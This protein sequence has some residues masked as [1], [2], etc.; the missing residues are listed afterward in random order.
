MDRPRR[1]KLTTFIK[2]FSDR[3][4]QI[5]QSHVDKTDIVCNSLSFDIHRQIGDP[6]Q[7]QAYIIFAKKKLIAYRNQGSTFSPQLNI[8]GPK[9]IDN[10][11]ATAC[12]QC[13]AI[14]DLIRKSFLWL[15]ENSMTMRRNKVCL[16][17]IF[18]Y[19]VVARFT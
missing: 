18:F 19:K 5:I 13:V 7:V 1:R 3:C 16:K 15:M 17:L 12:I 11:H 6:S 4:H 2:R 9:I 8:K 14:S 10:G